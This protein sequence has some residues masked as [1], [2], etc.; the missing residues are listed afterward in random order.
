MILNVLSL[1]DVEKAWSS[2][3]PSLKNKYLV[4]TE[5]DDDPELTVRVSNGSIRTLYVDQHTMRILKRG[6]ITK[7]LKP[8]TYEQIKEL[9][10]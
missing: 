10:K 2:V 7:V 9:Y 3:Q 5:K 4:M 8:F 6:G 1:R